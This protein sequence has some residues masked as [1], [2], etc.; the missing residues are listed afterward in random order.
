MSQR[1]GQPGNQNA[2]K[3]K[4]WAAAIESAIERRVS[5]GKL[6]GLEELAD[7]LI[8]AVLAGDLDAI[9]ELGNRLDGKPK[10][11]LEVEGDLGTVVRL[12]FGGKRVA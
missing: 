3:G 2:A 10:Q 5:E 6:K 1:G 11:Q 9:R 4:R 7:K 8:D 12:Q